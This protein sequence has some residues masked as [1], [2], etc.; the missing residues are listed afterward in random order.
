MER[1]TTAEEQTPTQ[2]ESSRRLDQY[3]KMIESYEKL[4][5]ELDDKRKRGEI[6]GEAFTQRYDRLQFDLEA[7][8]RRRRAI[9]AQL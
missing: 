8:K 2:S 5:A 6:S 3:D 4:C 7:Y 9:F 1:Q